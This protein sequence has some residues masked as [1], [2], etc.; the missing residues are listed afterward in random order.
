MLT[1]SDIESQLTQRRLDIQNIQIQTGQLQ[2]QLNQLKKDQ[3]TLEDSLKTLSTTNSDISTAS[4]GGYNTI[5]TPTKFIQTVN[6]AADIM[7]AGLAKLSAIVTAL[8]YPPTDSVT[9]IQVTKADGTTPIIN[10]D[11]TNK[12]IG[13]GGNVAPAYSLDVTGDINASGNIR[14]GGII[15]TS[16]KFT[17]R[18]ALTLVLGTIYQNIDTV[19]WAIV[20]SVFSTGLAATLDVLIDTLSTPVNTIG[21]EQYIAN[22]TS[23]MVTFLVLPNEYYQVN[24]SNMT[25]QYATKWK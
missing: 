4:T 20:V 3:K 1:Q 8:I 11:S 25:V 16:G 24:G 10:V 15:L 6:F 21:H 22:P 12:R 17:N 23:G 5:N 19:P 13:L 9:A 7:V 2:V 14:A 18:A